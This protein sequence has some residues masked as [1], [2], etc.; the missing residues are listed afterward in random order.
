MWVRFVVSGS[1]HTVG[2]VFG[3]SDSASKHRFLVLALDGLRMVVARSRIG[4]PRVLVA[5]IDAGLGEGGLGPCVLGVALVL[6]LALEVLVV[7]VAWAWVVLGQS[8]F[9]LSTLPCRILQ[10]ETA[11]IVLFDAGGSLMGA[12]AWF[13]ALVGPQVSGHHQFGVLGVT[14]HFHTERE[15]RRHRRFFHDVG[16]GAEAFLFL[17]FL[18]WN[19]VFFFI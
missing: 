1:G 19:V 14:A 12:G 7:V 15:L 6:I 9:R 2:V 5:S 8:R 11:S 10:T 17:S 4:V 18:S 16:T 3:C 13:L